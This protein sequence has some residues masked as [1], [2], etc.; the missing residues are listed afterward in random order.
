[1]KKNILITGGA[2]RIGKEIS[3]FFAK[4]GWNIAI[5]FNKSK[6]EALAVQKEIIKIGVKCSI[7]QA[8][9][10]KYNEVKSIIKKVSKK[11][12]TINCLVNCAS[13][14]ENDDIKKFNNQKW[15]S[16]FDINL[17]APAILCSEFTKQKNINNSNIIN[18]IDQRVFKL[19]PYFFSYTL[20]KA[21]LQTLTK[22]LAMKFAPNIRVNAIAPGPVM[23]N[24]RQSKLH[25]EKQ[26]KNTILQK[27]VRI[28]D[29]CSAIEFI[30]NN[31]SIT[32]MTIPVDSG[33]NLGWKTPDLINIKE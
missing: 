8:N 11:I 21:G 20:S 4:R 9:L 1:M 30:I 10:S 15:H 24:K 7:V 22:I 32:G 19:T 6:K 16:H 3:F 33:Q 13:I 12:G 25:F 28:E 2:Q 17:K 26:F 31:H 5:H 14:F 18:I 23:Q 27:Q 29:I